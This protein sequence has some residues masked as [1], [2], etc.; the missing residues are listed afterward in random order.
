MPAAPFRLLF[1][2]PGATQAIYHCSF[3]PTTQEGY[4]KVNGAE[5]QK[6]VLL[7]T[8]KNNNGSSWILL[9]LHPTAPNYQAITGE[10]AHILL[11]LYFFSALYLIKRGQVYRENK[12]R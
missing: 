4:N 8:N 12:G 10:E 6:M 3:H 5:T 9:S 2:T 1:V 11:S 7:L